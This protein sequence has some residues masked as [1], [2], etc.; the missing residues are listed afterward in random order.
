MYTTS[1]RQIYSHPGSDRKYDP[2]ELRR[3]LVIHT[4]GRLNEWV[5]E[6]NDGESEYVRALAEEKLVAAARKSFE[7]KPAVEAHGVTDQ[8]VLDY[9]AHYLEWLSTPSVTTSSPRPIARPCTDCP[10]PRATT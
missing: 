9:L 8:T 10:P 1:D 3:R 7:L 6:F 2:M 5:A 4:E